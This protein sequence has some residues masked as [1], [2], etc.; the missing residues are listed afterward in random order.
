LYGVP[1][2][3]ATSTVCAAESVSLPSASKER[4]VI[5]RGPSNVASDGSRVSSVAL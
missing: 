2:V 1:T 4:V 3:L 5:W